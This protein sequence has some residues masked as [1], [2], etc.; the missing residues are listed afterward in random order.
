MKLT[1]SSFLALGATMASVLCSC[2]VA[3][4]RG[5]GP[6]EGWGTRFQNVGYEI[7]PLSRYS[8]MM[9]KDGEGVD[10]EKPSR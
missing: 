10:A 5:G 7:N 1:S 3:A 9:A 2:S 6:S 4:Q 8:K